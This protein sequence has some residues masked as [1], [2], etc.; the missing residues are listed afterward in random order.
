MQKFSYP[1]EVPFYRIGA[2][3]IIFI[4][5]FFFSAFIYILL[6]FE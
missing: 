3:I 1:S 5:F 4:S 2:F 6:V